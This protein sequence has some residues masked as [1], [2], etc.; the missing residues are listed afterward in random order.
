MTGPATPGKTLRPSV[1]VA[2]STALRRVVS[3]AEPYPHLC[4]RWITGQDTTSGQP[5]RLDRRDCAACLAHRGPSR[6][7][8]PA[9]PDSVRGASTTTRRTH[10]PIPCGHW[11]GVES[12]H[13]GT[14]DAIRRYINGYRCPAHAPTRTHP[15]GA[16]IV[17]TPAALAGQPEPCTTPPAPLSEEASTVQAPAS[18]RLGYR[19]LVTGSR[20]WTDPAPITTALDQLYAEHG[21][22]LVV[23][24]GACPRG[25]DAIA[26]RWCHVAGVAVEEYP[27]DWT[28]H[29]PAGGMRRNTMMVA[30]R[31]QLCLAFIRD[32]SPGASHCTRLAQAAGIRTIRHT[33]TTNDTRRPHQPADRLLTAALRYTAA[34]IAVFLLGRSKRPV[35]NCP[36]CRTASPDHDPQTCDCLTCHG[37][38]AATTDPHRIQAM[39]D[40]VPDGLLAIR[41]GAAS[42][43]VVVDID[44]DHGGRL[45]PTLMTP[46]ATVAT[47][48][49]GWHLYY[50]HPDVSVLSRPLPGHPG[51]DIKADGGYVVAPPSL[52][53]STRRR[54]QWVGARPV[55]E[56]PPP[57]HTACRTDPPPRPTTPPAAAADRPVPLRAAGGISHP[58]ALLAAHLGAVTAAPVGRRR[59]TLYGAAR[60]VARL[61]AAG[62]ITPADAVAALTDAG[63]TAQQSDRDIHA[64]ITGGFT[65]EG[66][67]A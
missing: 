21:E 36:T 60:G 23:V 5:R 25:A 55:T 20:T 12:R 34:G 1:W 9:T 26:D 51:V 24:H 22:A 31:P 57:L 45:D 49:G 6:H 30:T 37:F 62:A 63:R 59:T 61:V 42:R 14:V 38:Y 10:R 39:L 67:A 32:H 4:G 41:T 43:L 2:A 40:T 11:I 46:T 3:T 8:E 65:A 28:L 58:T 48:G 47:G 66:V 19:V 15:P 54:Y 64:A 29:G 18:V 33:T 7:T 13:C 52:H 16:S 17:P 53:P 44:P 35:A 27:A 50:R 56:M